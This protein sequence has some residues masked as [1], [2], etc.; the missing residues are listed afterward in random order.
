MPHHVAIKQGLLKAEFSEAI[1]GHKKSKSA[2]EKVA[3]LGK[4]HVFRFAHPPPINKQK[5]ILKLRPRILLQLHL[6]SDSSRPSPVVDVLPSSIFPSR[7]PFK[8]AKLFRGKAG[9]GPQDLVLVRSDAQEQHAPLNGD[10]NSNKDEKWDQKHIIATICRSRN[11]SSNDGS[12]AEI[13]FS[14]GQ[15]WTGAPLPNGSYE[16]TSVSDDGT[17]TRA[18]WVLRKKLHQRA[19]SGHDLQRSLEEPP[20]QRF[21]FSLI[22]PTKRRHAVIASM[23]RDCISVSDRYQPIV[24]PIYSRTN[25]SQSNE[26]PSSP[27]SASPTDRSQFDDIDPTEILMDK[28]V[29]IDDEVRTL[30]TTTATW[31]MFKEGWS[32]NFSYEDGV[33]SSSAA[34]H[35]HTGNGNATRDDSKPPVVLSEL[36]ESRTN[37]KNLRRST[38][39]ALKGS[40]MPKR[41]S[42]A[43]RSESTPLGMQSKKI[44]HETIFP[45]PNLSASA[46]YDSEAVALQNISGSGILDVGEENLAGNVQ[47]KGLQNMNREAPARAPKPANESIGAHG[48]REK[49]RKF[50][51]AFALVR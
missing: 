32:K 39:L 29:E 22:D 43:R 49:W 26:N 34:L 41:Y 44:K 50:R 21:G 45:P 35:A 13:T 51:G 36:E 17:V 30:I 11:L 19:A 2:D 15:S 28:L 16:F 40:R 38:S 42:S 24:D 6:E 3:K 48:C 10:Q 12:G 20:A 46:F 47:R 4:K 14:H 1:R 9:L 27:G 18:R 5:Q 8:F 31:V 37:G 33:S 23:T 7:I 25:S